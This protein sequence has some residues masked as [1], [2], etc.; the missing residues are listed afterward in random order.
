MKRYTFTSQL[1]ALVGAFYLL[2]GAVAWYQDIGRIPAIAVGLGVLYLFRA[3][4]TAEK[5]PSRARS[6]E[7]EDD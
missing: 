5:R 2:A 3:M 4:D 1:L 7:G 6:S